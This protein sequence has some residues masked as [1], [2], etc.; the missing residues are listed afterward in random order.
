MLKF[1]F[2]WEE[3]IGGNT[4]KEIIEAESFRQARCLFFDRHKNTPHIIRA[5]WNHDINE[6]YY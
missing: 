6:R 1:T 2:Y 3:I 5:V 4:Y